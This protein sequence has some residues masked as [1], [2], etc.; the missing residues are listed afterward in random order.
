M[1]V[2]TK[3]GSLAIFNLGLNSIFNGRS[4]QHRE[5]C[6]FTTRNN[7]DKLFVSC[8]GGCFSLSGNM[9]FPGNRRGCEQNTFSHCM[10]RRRHFISTSHMMLHV[11]AWLKAQVEMCAR[12]IS[13]HL[14]VRVMSHDLLSTPSILSY[15]SLFLY[16]SFFHLL[17]LK[18][19]HVQNTLRRFT[20][21]Q[22]RRFDG[23]R[24]S[25]K[26]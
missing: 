8:S 11:H 9:Q 26:L 17:K 18:V 14:L 1:E 21:P 12:N 23:S 3:F 10:Y 22:R 16:F 4:H 13:S 20:R 2:E 6:G 19:D 15:F 7:S 24:T 5:T 25:H